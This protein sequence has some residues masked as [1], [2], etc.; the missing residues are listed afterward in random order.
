[1]RGQESCGQGLKGDY[2]PSIQL[3]GV[4][5]L[6]LVVLAMAD[7]WTNDP[8]VAKT[9]PAPLAQKLFAG[10][11]ADGLRDSSKTSGPSLVKICTYGAP[12]L[13]AGLFSDANSLMRTFTTPACADDSSVYQFGPAMQPLFGSALEAMP[14]MTTGSAGSPV[15]FREQTEASPNRSAFT[16]TRFS[17]PGNI[18]IRLPLGAH[19]TPGSAFHPSSGSHHPNR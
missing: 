13:G 1:M 14:W 11:A 2:T 16:V 8:D 5:V 18:V 12:P 10:D 9:L 6:S 17:G 7:L 4:R 19:G 15:H 3:C